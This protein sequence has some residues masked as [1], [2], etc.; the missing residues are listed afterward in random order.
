MN[1]GRIRELFVVEDDDKQYIKDMENDFNKN[2]S[3]IT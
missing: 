2:V 3:I 1:D